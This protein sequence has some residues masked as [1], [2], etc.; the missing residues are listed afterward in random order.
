MTLSELPKLLTALGFD[1]QQTPATRDS[2]TLAELEYDQIDQYWRFVF[3][4]EDMQINV[5]PQSL[6]DD[7]WQAVEPHASAG[8]NDVMIYI[9]SPGTWWT[10]ESDW[11]EI[12]T[13]LHDEIRKLTAEALRIA[14]LL[15][16]WAE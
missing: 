9:V 2:I 3:R 5:P 6:P 7:V 16:P 15:A 1:I 14:K 10:E 8:Y 13:G 12:E 11:R 4:W